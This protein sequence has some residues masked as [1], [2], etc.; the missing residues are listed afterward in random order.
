MVQQQ[1]FNIY[2][3]KSLQLLDLC[4]ILLSPTSSGPVI[5]SEF[6]NLTCNSYLAKLGENV[7]ITCKSTKEITSVKVSFCSHHNDSCSDKSSIDLYAVD[8]GRIS[9]KK[10]VNSVHLNI[11]NI[12]IS[13]HRQYN[14]CVKTNNGH[15]CQHS[16][17]KVNAPYTI[18]EVRWQNDTTI[19][20]KAS[21]GFPKTQLYWFDK[22]GLNLTH[23]SKLEATEAEDG[24]FFLSSTLQVESPVDEIYCCSFNNTTCSDSAWAAQQITTPNKLESEEHTTRSFI[25]IGIV[26]VLVIGVAFFCL[27]R[28]RKGAN[29]VYWPRMIIRKAPKRTN[30]TRSSL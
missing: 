4:L 28:R 14:I 12:Q 5:S 24:S 7:T 19:V 9:L 22:N 27:Y 10:N 13:D 26:P 16:F 15:R 1:F 3:M 11:H 21:G 2:L 6:A 8:N 17:L 25:L 20:C 23:S 18:D 29:D 30:S